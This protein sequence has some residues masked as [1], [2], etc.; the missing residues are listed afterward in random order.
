MTDDYGHK[1]SP[2]N[3]MKALGR[4]IKLFEEILAVLRRIETNTKKTEIHNYTSSS[5][6]EFISYKDTHTQPHTPRGNKNYNNQTGTKRG[7]K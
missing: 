5:D 1:A 3:V 7:N 6:Y 2:G 4:I